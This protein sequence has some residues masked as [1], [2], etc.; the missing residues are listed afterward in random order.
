MWAEREIFK[1]LTECN[2]RQG[3]EIP[4]HVVS[5]ESRV[6]ASKIDKNPWQPEPSYAERFLTVRTPAEMLE[7]GNICWFTRAVFPELGERRGLSKDYYSLLGRSCYE[8][9]L[10]WSEIYAVQTMYRHFDF[11]A[12]TVYT[13][14]RYQ[15]E[16][17][18]MWD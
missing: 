1:I 7:L 6:L 16:F 3:W 13:A 2:Q 4:E 15:Q 18:E 17:R 12:E 11:L 9:V 5:Y 8:S 10:K 14:L